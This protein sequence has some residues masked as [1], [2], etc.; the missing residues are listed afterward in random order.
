MTEEPTVFVVDDDADLCDSLRWL[1]ESDGLRVETHTSAQSFLDAYTPDRPG[2]LL[3]D[4]RMPG[5]NGLEL[6]QHLKER[7][8]G[9][10]IIILTGHATVPMAVRA[11]QAGALDFLQKPVDVQALLGRISEAMRLDAQNRQERVENEKILSRL[12]SLTP[13]ERE[14]LDAVVAGKSNKQIAGELCIADKTVEV[15]RKHLMKKMRVRSVV[16]LV[17]AVLRVLR[18]DRPKP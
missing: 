13:R 12:A 17:R 9:I 4:I 16:E 2:V 10:P 1:L 11:V 8:F 18:G 6:Q 3:L 15:H 7:G 5:M 14:V